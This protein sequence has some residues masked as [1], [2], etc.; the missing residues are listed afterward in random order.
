MH[1]ARVKSDRLV[2][3]NQP[4]GRRGAL[5][6]RNGAAKSGLCRGPFPRE[7]QAQRADPTDA[8]QCVVAAVAPGRSKTSSTETSRRSVRTTT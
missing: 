6:I 1:D 8:D 5:H 4:S 3:F 2:S 7:I